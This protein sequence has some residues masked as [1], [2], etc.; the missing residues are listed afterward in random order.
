[1]IIPVAVH[2]L[3]SDDSYGY[4]LWVLAQDGSGRAWY[5]WYEHEASLSIDAPKMDMATTG[6]IVGDPSQRY[7]GHAIT[8]VPINTEMDTEILDTWWKQGS[9]PDALKG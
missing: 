1:M 8:A 2:P 9:I 7:A 5:K 6:E 4:K 3:Q